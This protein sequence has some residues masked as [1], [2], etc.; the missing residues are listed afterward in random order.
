MNF[1]FDITIDTI[2]AFIA[3]VLAVYS[4]IYTWKANQFSIELSSTFK[5][6]NRNQT[7][8]EFCVIN[9]SSNPLVIKNIELFL[10]KEQ[11]FDN[12]FSPI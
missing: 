8:V 3:L 1:S 11:V 7:R 6:N 9:T 2:M 12:G 10:E 4:T 5:A